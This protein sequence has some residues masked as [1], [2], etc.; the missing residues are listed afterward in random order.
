MDVIVGPVSPTT[1]WNLGEKIDDPLTM[2]L[3]DIYTISA[4]LAGIPG[5]S[6]PCGFVDSLPVGL[7][8]LGK[9]FDEETI[10]KVGIAFEQATDWKKEKPKL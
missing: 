1:A 10:L 7:Q 6:V 2:Y 3:Q 9:Q 8:I 5:L 4:N